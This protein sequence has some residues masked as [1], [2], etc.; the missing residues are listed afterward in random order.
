MLALSTAL[1]RGCLLAV[2]VLF[3]CKSW[4]VFLDLLSVGEPVL[5]CSVFLST[6]ELFSL[7]ECVYVCACVCERK[8]EIDRQRDRDRE[9]EIPRS[10]L[11]I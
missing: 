8:T 10:F 3:S 7:H 6:T 2:G 5:E 4:A 11:P 1:C 9:T